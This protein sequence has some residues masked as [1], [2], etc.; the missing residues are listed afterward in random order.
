MDKI[1]TREQVIADAKA[2]AIHA[3]EDQ[4]AERVEDLAQT[5]LYMDER[6]KGTEWA[7]ID[8][9]WD[10]TDDLDPWFVEA[11]EILRVTL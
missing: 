3:T 5:L 6:A 7:D 9:I 1:E 11:R 4:R 2:N 10:S 8:A